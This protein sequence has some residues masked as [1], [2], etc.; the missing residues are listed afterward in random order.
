M[1]DI[2]KDPAMTI[3][4]WGKGEA[5][6]VRSPA[7]QMLPTEC[8]VKADGDI[9]DEPSFAFVCRGAGTATVVVIQVSLRMLM[10]AVRAALDISLRGS[11]V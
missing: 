2:T 5:I 1:K 4:V 9:N 10:P 7:V 11:E 8:H 6:P 3:Q